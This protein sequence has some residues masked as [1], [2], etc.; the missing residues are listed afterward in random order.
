M[1]LD[2]RQYSG[3]LHWVCA[4]QVIYSPLCVG[5]RKCDHALLAERACVQAILHAAHLVRQLQKS[6]LLHLLQHCHGMCMIPALQRSP[7][8]PS[9]MCRYSLLQ[10]A[11]QFMRSHYQKRRYYTLRSLG[12]VRQNLLGM[13]GLALD[14][15]AGLWPCICKDISERLADL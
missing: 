4:L 15:F 5:D 12:Q 9:P 14:V 2:L 3:V 11:M 13:R 7:S 10:G 6:L 1:G 8:P